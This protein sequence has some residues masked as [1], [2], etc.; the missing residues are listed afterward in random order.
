MKIQNAI[1]SYTNDS[2]TVKLDGSANEKL[3]VDTGGLQ[4]KLESQRQRAA[5]AGKRNRRT[6]YRGKD[7]LR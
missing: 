2:L 4:Q 3:C 5:G 1:V 7:S 6:F